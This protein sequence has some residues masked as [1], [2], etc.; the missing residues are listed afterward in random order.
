MPSTPRIRRAS[1]TATSSPRTSSSP[2]AGRRRC[3]TSAWPSCTQI[4]PGGSEV[5]ERHR[6]AVTELALTTAGFGGRHCGVHVARTGARRT[7]RSRTDL[8]SFGVVLYEMLTGKEAFTGSTTAVIFHAI[9]GEPAPLVLSLNPA[10]PAKARRNRPEDTRE[11]QR[12]PL[13][14][15]S[16][17]AG[18]PEAPEARLRFRAI[19]RR[20]LR[21][22][23]GRGDS[24]ARSGEAGSRRYP[25]VASVP[26]PCSSRAGWYTGKG[27][28]G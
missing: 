21:E 2:S 8:F 3:W 16:R 13:S 14:D 22:P 23:A 12:P 7:A 19:R 6:S 25:L 28:S 1:S 24:T 9:L 11:G 27:P 10:L 20:Q 5:G 15:G 4:G 26:R 18:R 17:T